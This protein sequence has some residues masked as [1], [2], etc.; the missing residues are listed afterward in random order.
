MEKDVYFRETWKE[1]I[2]VEKPKNEGVWGEKI[3]PMKQSCYNRKLCT[4]GS[5]STS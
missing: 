3:S 4:G 2:F 1:L 5:K